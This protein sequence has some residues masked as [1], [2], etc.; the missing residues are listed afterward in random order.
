MSSIPPSLS[1]PPQPAGCC[2]DGQLGQIL[3]S[4]GFTPCAPA[5]GALVSVAL[6]SV[7]LGSV[8]MEDKPQSDL[9]WP[10]SHIA[11]GS[12]VPEFRTP[13]PGPSV[14]VAMPQFALYSPTGHA[15]HVSHTGPSALV[16]D[17]K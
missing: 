11:Q 3:H 17:N 14:P 9:Y 2:P 8:A 13:I 15:L 6:A 12:Q 16:H 5:T 10:L 4:P 1:Y 7:V